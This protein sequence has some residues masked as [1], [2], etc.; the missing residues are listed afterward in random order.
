LPVLDQAGEVGPPVFGHVDELAVEQHASGVEQPGLLDQRRDPRGPVLA[1]ATEHADRGAVDPELHAI[2]IELD[3][4][5]PAVSTRYLVDQ[6]R[7]LGLYESR[8]RYITHD[9]P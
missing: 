7:Q 9:H 2:S 4:V 8:Q 6:R 3:L 5:D 1:I